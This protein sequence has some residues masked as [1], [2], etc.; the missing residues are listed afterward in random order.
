MD[1]A[2]G[3]ERIDRVRAA[4]FAATQDELVDHGYDGLS[5]EG[6]ARRAGVPEHV[7]TERWTDADALM[8][9]MLEEFAEHVLVLP[10]S[11]SLETD[12]RA[13]AAGI[14]AFYGDPRPRATISA[15]VHAAGCSERAAETLR[16]FFEHRTASA[17]EPV[18]RAIANRE[19]PPD[20]DPVE[21]IRALGAPFYYRMF[22]T[23]EPLDHALAERTAAATLAAA[24]AGVL[25][26][27]RVPA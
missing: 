9:L 10:N 22:I 12:M 26:S 11:G 16:R 27:S 8:E 18:R 6:V 15:L 24:R 2:G 19:L 7:V 5:V 21:V 3:N 14:A 20:T 13:L 1:K 4:V 25:T 17:A 23:H